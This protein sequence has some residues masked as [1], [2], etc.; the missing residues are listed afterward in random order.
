ATINPTGVSL[1]VTPSHP[2][3]AVQ[4]RILAARILRQLRDPTSSHVAVI[5][6]RTLRPH[7]SSARLAYENQTFIPI[8]RAHFRLPLPKD[9]RGLRTLSARTRRLARLHPHVDS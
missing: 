3:I 4:K 8:D 9:P 6:T 5:P 2:G 7:V 1:N